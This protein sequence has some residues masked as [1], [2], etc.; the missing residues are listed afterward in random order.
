[1]K[2]ILLLTAL[3]LVAFLEIRQLFNSQSQTNI[4]KQIEVTNEATTTGIITGGEIV[5][6][7]YVIDG[8][9]IDLTDGRRVRYIG[10]DAPE[11]AHA[12][13]PAECFGIAAREENKRMVDGKS[14]RLEKDS[15]DEDSYGRLLRYVF[16]GPPASEA[17]EDLVNEQLVK[18]G[19]ADAWNVPP[20]EKYKSVLFTA[21]TEARE[22]HRGLW[23]TC[24]SK[25]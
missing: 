4:Q 15:S 17:G 25:N 18:N 10:I 5:T 2:R 1:M 13:K 16:V 24:R 9:T 19:F 21:Q 6:V 23:E 8:D 11:T 22:S 14:V 20:D 7:A 3:L 12:Q